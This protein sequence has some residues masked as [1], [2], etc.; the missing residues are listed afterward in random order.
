[1]TKNEVIKTV[2]KIP[3]LNQEEDSWQDICPLLSLLNPVNF[4]EITLTA[5]IQQH[6]SF[7]ISPSD[8]QDENFEYTGENHCSFRALA[9]T[10]MKRRKV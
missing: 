9:I 8:M 4:E 3:M 7:Y 1:M 10:N 5:C 2:I 6:C